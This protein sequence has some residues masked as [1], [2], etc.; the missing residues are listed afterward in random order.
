MALLAI[1]V[2]AEMARGR[3]DSTYAEEAR[4]RM[5]VLYHDIDGEMMAQLE[6]LSEDLM[7]VFEPD[8]IEEAPVSSTVTRMDV[9]DAVI[10]QDWARVLTLM[11]VVRHPLLTASVRLG[12]MARAYRHLVSP[13]LGDLFRG[14]S[15]RVQEER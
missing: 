6:G 7:W 10:T 13:W 12:W 8:F 4:E 15:V 2:R 5:D 1:A 9:R 11:R 3:G 14:A